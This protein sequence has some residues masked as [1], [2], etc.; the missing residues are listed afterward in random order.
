MAHP[1]YRAWLYILTH[2]FVD[3]RIELALSPMLGKIENGEVV[4]GELHSALGQVLAEER[5]ARRKDLD[6]IRRDF[7]ALEARLAALQGTPGTLPEVKEWQPETV[8][9]RG[10]LVTHDGAL[11]QARADTAQQPGRW[12]W[13]LVA[14]S[15]RDALS[16]KMRASLRREHKISSVRLCPVWWFDVHRDA[17]RARGRAQDPAQT[18]VVWPG[19][20]RFVAGDGPALF[21]QACARGLEGIVSKRRSSPYRSGRSPHWLKAKNPARACSQAGRRPARYI[22]WNLERPA[23]E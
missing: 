23:A 15:G 3:W 13:S 6:E 22:C 1:N 17:R 9:Y 21:A 4:G 7:A 14:R 11:W 20:Q 10:Q 19:A 18:R 8:V 2:N 16:P 5:R 12:D